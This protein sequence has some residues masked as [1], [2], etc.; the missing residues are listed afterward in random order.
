MAYV[1]HAYAVSVYL[2]LAERLTFQDSDAKTIISYGS[3]A[4]LS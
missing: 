1:R 3:E 4:F 2:G